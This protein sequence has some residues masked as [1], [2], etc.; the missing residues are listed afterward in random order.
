MRVG[1]VCEHAVGFFRPIEEPRRH[2]VFRQGSN[3]FDPIL[4]REVGVVHE[5][6]VYADRTGELS[7]AAKEAPENEVQIRSF[8]FKPHRFDEA[9]DR[10]VFLAGQKERHAL[11]IG[12]RGLRNFRFVLAFFDAPADPAGRK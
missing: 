10:L 8:G 6:L 2:E 11:R 5:R 1:N 7:A 3:G 4:R 12:L 9:V